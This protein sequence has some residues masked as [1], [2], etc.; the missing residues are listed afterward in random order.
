MGK[1]L[2]KHPRLPSLN[3]I[4][5]YKTDIFFIDLAISLSKK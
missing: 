4:E 2:E 3:N 5:W 1:Q